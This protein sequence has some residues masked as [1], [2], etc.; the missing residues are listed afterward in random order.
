MPMR[1]VAA[2]L[3]VLAGCG[4]TARESYLPDGTRGFHVSCDG[5][6]GAS[7]DCYAKAGD[8]CGAKGYVLMNSGGMASTRDFFFK[9]KD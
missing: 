4:T 2:C 7:G 9:C 1:Y 6:W 8:V 3:V 5:L